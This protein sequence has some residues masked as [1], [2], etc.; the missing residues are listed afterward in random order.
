MNSKSKSFVLPV[1]LRW[2]GAACFGEWETAACRERVEPD[3]L[4]SGGNRSATL[5]VRFGYACAPVPQAPAAQLLRLIALTPSSSATCLSGRPLLSSS[6]T[7]SRRNA[8]HPTPNAQRP[9]SNAQRP[10]SNVQHPTPNVQHP[11]PNV[12]RPTSNAQHPTPNVQ[13]P[14]PNVKRPTS[15]IQRPTSMCNRTVL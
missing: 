9:T 11:T 12:Q 1:Q 5:N 2:A 3:H 7:A 15:N 8:Q 4:C 13:H 6:S 14:T 10:T